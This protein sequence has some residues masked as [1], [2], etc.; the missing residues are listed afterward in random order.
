MIETH[1]VNALLNPSIKETGLYKVISFINGLVAPSFLFCAGLGLA[2]TLSR[3]REAFLTPGKTL[4]RYLARLG[5]LLIVA[6]SLHLPFFSWTKLKGIADANTWIPFYQADILQVIALTLLLT[7][8]FVQIFRTERRF[9]IALSASA[10]LFVF[11]APLLRNL[12]LGSL[13]PWLQPYLTN[14]VKSQF[15][16]F[17]WSAF[18]IGGVLAGMYLFRHAEDQRRPAAAKLARAGILAVAAAL[19][20]EAAPLTLYPA[21]SFFNA[22]PEFFF[23]RFGII[24]CI[25]AG[26]WAA[27][28]PSAPAKSRGMILFGQ[29]SLIVYVTHLLVVYGYTYEWSFVR[30]YGP[31]L[32]YAGCA[33]LFAALS[34]AMYL[35]AFGWHAIK[36]WNA[37]TARAVQYAF[38]ALMVVIFFVKQT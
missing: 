8:I 12:D 5:F 18:L 22:S 16:L 27:E 31:T 10:V 7:V 24:L 35:L 36:R 32:G 9:V 2:I 25:L 17:P 19:L 28:R 21:H 14:R 34:A 38:V 3:R 13:P 33:G 30:L 23:V 37:Q 26:F 4:F 15:P 6:Y 20:C 1:V 29:E 11:L